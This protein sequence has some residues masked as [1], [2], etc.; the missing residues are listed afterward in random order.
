[1]LTLNVQERDLK[2]SAK[3][4][5]KDGKLP[6]VYYGPKDKP[7]AILA[8]RIEFSKILRDAGESTVV[9]LK[10]PKATVEALIHDVS[11]DPVSSEI[12]HADFYVPEKGK[13]V[14]VEVPLEFVGVSIAIKD[15]GGT[16]I[17]VLHEIE[18]EALPADLPHSI[19]VD[20]SALVTLESQI[21]AKDIVLPK[22]VSLI[23]ES[24]EVVASVAE[25]QEEKTETGSSDISTIEVE[26]KGK[27]D[28]EG[29]GES[30]K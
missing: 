24:D 18:I 9:T 21:T 11:Y 8:D 12:I 22:G 15:L 30:K 20:I 23:T 14:E 3:A 7:V 1:M 6:C 16:L 4:L 25:Q 29:E 27:K 17:K 10:T 26:K 2:Q 13:K 19:K 5:R 28:E